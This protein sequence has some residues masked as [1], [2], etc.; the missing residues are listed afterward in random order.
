MSQGD[1]QLNHRA[2]IHQPLL[3]HFS[4]PAEYFNGKVPGNNNDSRVLSLVN[5]TPGI[6]MNSKKLDF[7]INTEIRISCYKGTQ[8]C[9]EGTQ[10]CNAPH[11]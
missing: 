3:S 9:S 11:F 2:D 4:L 10:F 8:F 1:E 7:S 5:H 6:Q